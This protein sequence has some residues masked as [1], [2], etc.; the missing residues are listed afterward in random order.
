LA[1]NAKEVLELLHKGV[2]ERRFITLP[3]NN[4]MRDTCTSSLSDGPLYVLKTYQILGP[5]QP[6][7]N[8]TIKQQNDILSQNLN[9]AQEQLKKMEDRA[10]DDY[11]HIMVAGDVNSGKSAFINGLLR[12][13]ILPSG[14]RSLTSTFVEVLDAQDLD[15]SEAVHLCRRGVEYDRENEDTFEREDIDNLYDIMCDWS[16]KE[17]NTMYDTIKLYI[18]YR[19]IDNNFLNNIER[20]VHIIDS[21]GLN[22]SADETRF[23]FKKQQEIDVL[24]LIIDARNGLTESSTNIMRSYCE[25]RTQLFVI[26]THFDGVCICKKGKCY[27]SCKEDC[28]QKIMDIIKRISPKTVESANELI[29][30]V[31]PTLVPM[32]DDESGGVVGEM[33]PEWAYMEAYLHI[34]IYDQFDFHKLSPI[35]N[36]LQKLMHDAIL[37]S[38]LNLDTL[39]PKLN[40]KEM[41]INQL[42]D[43]IGQLENRYDEAYIKARDI[44]IATIN[45]IH[46]NVLR[47]VNDLKNHPERFFNR[48]MIELINSKA[49]EGELQRL[50]Q[51]KW[52]EFEEWCKHAIDMCIQDCTSE[53]EKLVE[54][55]PK[56][57]TDVCFTSIKL[58]LQ[59]VNFDASGIRETEQSLK[60]KVEEMA[61]KVLSGSVKN[62]KRTWRDFMCQTL[63]DKINK[64]SKDGLK[65]IMDNSGKMDSSSDERQG[66]G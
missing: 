13:D 33:P 53:I 60:Y 26:I 23:L 35:K 40:E 39:E 7:V 27:R 5:D 9:S 25:K 36:Y 8:M 43:D 52:N 56:D 62:S 12:R 19:R 20:K 57:S 18:D 46:S 42:K 54:G 15:G 28:K 2:E 30:C 24:I 17:Y 41:E 6:Y 48:E 37:I 3:T 55:L 31:N 10:K 32:W 45:N 1:N 38:K 61:Q 44:I 21:V 59:D 14:G 65:L 34:F 66:F 51:E 63:I 4:N 58:I 29:H 64:Y 22:T 11:Y 49:T 16:K 47:I 50:L